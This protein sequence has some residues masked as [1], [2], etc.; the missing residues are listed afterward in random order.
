MEGTPTN[1]ETAQENTTTVDTSSAQGTDNASTNTGVT[2]PKDV[3]K[4]DLEIKMLRNRLDAISKQQES[5]I[6][7]TLEE[8]E[9]YRAIAE[10]AT[11]QLEELL[12]ERQETEASKLRED[13]TQDVFKSFD[14]KIVELAKTTGLKVEDATEEAKEALKAKL[15]KIAAT[16]GVATPNVQGSNPAPVTPVEENNMNYLPKQKAFGA[17]LVQ[18]RQAVASNGLTA[19]K[20]IKNLESI[21]AMKQIAGIEPQNL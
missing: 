20:Q 21:K 16:I 19:S 10:K 15:E 14:N 5:T 2:S 18:N 4:K 13:A 7:K 6:N 9:D 12:K 11:Q 17:D 3:E 1:G 8:K